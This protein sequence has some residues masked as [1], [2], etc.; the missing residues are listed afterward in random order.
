[1]TDVQLE[2]LERYFKPVYYVEYEIV[3]DGELFPKVFRMGYYDKRR[4][5]KDALQ[6]F[7]QFD[8]VRVIEK[9]MRTGQEKIIKERIPA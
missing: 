6:A 7:E 8:G 2:E 4:N 5:K 9:N 1:M 3:P